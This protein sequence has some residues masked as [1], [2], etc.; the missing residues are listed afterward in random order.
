MRKFLIAAVLIAA[1]SLAFS[2]EFKVGGLIIDHPVAKTTPATA[3]SG[4]GYLSITNTGDEADSLIGVE[5]D[6]PRVMIHDT[7]V[8]NDVATMFHI[9]AAVIAPG[10]TLTFAPGGKH[11]MFMGLDGDPFE[12]GETVEA[13]LVFENAGRLDV[14]FNV[15]TLEQ[16][17]DAIG[18]GEA[19]TGMA[20]GEGHDAEMDQDHS[21]H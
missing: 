18:K 21:N 14:V 4:A 7:K 11:I 5:A 15:E 3:M 13:T 1:P 10:E 19:A 9:D 6:F 16:I 2:H 8:E 20:E 12:V 17:I